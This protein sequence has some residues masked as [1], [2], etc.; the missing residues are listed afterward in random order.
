[1]T[2]TGA[3]LW[4]GASG[5]VRMITPISLSQSVVTFAIRLRYLE[6]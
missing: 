4:K 1:M 5:T 3:Y 2:K 6:I